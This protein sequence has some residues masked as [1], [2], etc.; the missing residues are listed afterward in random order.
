[1]LESLIYLT[2]FWQKKYGFY[3]SKYSSML[4]EFSIKQCHTKLFLKQHTQMQT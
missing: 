1:M 3:M 4:K 2:K